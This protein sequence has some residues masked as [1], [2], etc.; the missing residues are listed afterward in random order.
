MQRA[1]EMEL[2]G[3]SEVLVGTMTGTGA[4]GTVWRAVIGCAEEDARVALIDW[5]MDAPCQRCLGATSMT[6]FFLGNGASLFG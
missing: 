3:A 4:L 2:L 1:C 5:L 6:L